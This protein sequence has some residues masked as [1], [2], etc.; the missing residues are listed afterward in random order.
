[1][2]DGDGNDDKNKVGISYSLC[3]FDYK[4]QRA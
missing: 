3:F 4:F 2:I 1:M